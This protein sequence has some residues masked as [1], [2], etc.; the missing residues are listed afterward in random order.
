MP[1]YEVTIKATV[2][3]TIKVEADNE[4]EAQEAA[5]GMFTTTCEEGED[6]NYD[7]ETISVEEVA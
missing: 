4:D 2:Q 3:K 5:R 7:E 6:E 1:K